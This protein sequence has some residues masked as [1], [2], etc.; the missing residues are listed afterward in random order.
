MTK[1]SRAQHQRA[2]LALAMLGVLSCI[3]GCGSTKAKATITTKPAKATIASVKQ[4]LRAAGFNV[5]TTAPAGSATAAVYVDLGDSAATFVVLSYPTPA[6]AIASVTPL[7]TQGVKAGR[8]LLEISGTF[9]Y[10]LGVD[11]HVTSA[12][13][14]EFNKA[15]AAGKGG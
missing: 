6:D 10:G 8:G 1:L 3:A 7:E 2:R 9:V 12:E 11:H 14:A 15:Y 4:R 13:R 5:T